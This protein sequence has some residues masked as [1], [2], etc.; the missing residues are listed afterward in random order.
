MEPPEKIGSRG[1]VLGGMFA[2]GLGFALYLADCF[3]AHE[4]HGDVPWIFSGVY[5]Q[6]PFGFVLSLVF[7]GGGLLYGGFFFF[8]WLATGK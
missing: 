2:I 8:K 6:S 5:N 7:A 4:K 3:M 1:K